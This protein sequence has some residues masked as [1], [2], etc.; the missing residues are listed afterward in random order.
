MPGTMSRADLVA[1]LKASLHDAADVFTADADADFSRM[2]DVSALDLGRYRP[3]ILNGSIALTAG[4]D[5]YDAP[6]GM[7]SFSRELWSPGRVPAPW[8]AGYP[9][10]LPRISMVGTPGA[11]K[12]LF[13]PA[14]TAAHIAALGAVFAFVYLAAH[15]IDDDA[16]DTTI[17][18]E[19]RHALL[20]RAQAEAMREMAMRNTGKSQ[21]RV[22]GGGSGTPRNGTPAALFSVLMEEFK[23]A[24]A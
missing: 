1:D 19:L 20:L 10:P 4:T 23:A 16:A 7:V 3:Q 17:P 18:P 6:A 15:A 11:R 9:G 14:P 24:L 21:V 12:L 2:L 13:S 22:D 8:E 5:L